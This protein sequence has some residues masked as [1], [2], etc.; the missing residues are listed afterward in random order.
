M[1]GNSIPETN[2]NKDF[3][4]NF[5]SAL[6]EY[7]SSDQVEDEGLPTAHYFGSKLNLSS[8]YLSDL[9]KKETGKKY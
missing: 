2:I 3:V 5:E 9:L 8:N 1:T 6:K 7:F 4:V